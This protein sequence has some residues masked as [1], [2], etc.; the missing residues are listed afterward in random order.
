MDGLVSNKSVPP[1]VKTSW[2]KLK[3]NLT[4]VV[5]PLLNAGGNKSTETSAHSV[6]ADIASDAKLK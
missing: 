5:G 4:T 2:I 1:V 6:A 3:R